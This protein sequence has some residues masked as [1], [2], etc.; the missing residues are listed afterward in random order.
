MKIQ[1]RL[2]TFAPLRLD[3]VMKASARNARPAQWL[4][5]V[6]TSQLKH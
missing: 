1:S 5:A 2:R 3:S 4:H 6:V